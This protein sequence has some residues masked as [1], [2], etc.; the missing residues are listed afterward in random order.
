MINIETQA[1]NTLEILTHFNRD[2]L[3]A[4][5]MKNI[6]SENVGNLEYELKSKEALLRANLELY[7]EKEDKNDSTGGL[8]EN[9]F[10]RAKY[11]LSDTLVKVETL[12]IQ[13]VLP[14]MK[15]D[16]AEYKKKVESS[17]VDI[18]QANKDDIIENIN[19]SVDMVGK[20]ISSGKKIWELVKEHKE[21]FFSIG[22]M[23]SL[24]IRN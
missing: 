9:E 18:D 23:F 3:T 13:E 24:L 5:K 15:D 6:Y 1:K 19:K 20:I 14:R 4:G 11:A 17:G 16:L 7:Q 21:V 8:F 2:V 10:K 22:K 12:W